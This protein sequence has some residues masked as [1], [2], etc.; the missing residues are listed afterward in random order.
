[1]DVIM[2]TRDLLVL[3]AL[4]RLASSTKLDSLSVYMLGRRTCPAVAGEPLRPTADMSWILDHM[5]D[6]GHKLSLRRLR[7]DNFCV[8]GN[9]TPFQLHQLTD[10]ARLDHLAVSCFSIVSGCNNALQPHTFH[11]SCSQIKQLDETAKFC[12]RE[13]TAESVRHFLSECIRLKELVITDNQEILTEEVVRHLGPQLQDLQYHS[14]SLLSSRSDLKILDP[15]VTL[16][17]SWLAHCRNLLKLTIDTPIPRAKAFVPYVSSY[18][19]SLPSLDRLTCYCVGEP[20]VYATHDE[21][22]PDD[23]K[24]IICDAVSG[25]HEQLLRRQHRL[26]A[27]CIAFEPRPHWDRDP[28]VTRIGRRP[29][30]QSRTFN[31]EI[32]ASLVFGC[33]PTVQAQCMELQEVRRAQRHLFWE[34]HPH[35]WAFALARY[36]KLALEESAVVRRT[37]SGLIETQVQSCSR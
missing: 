11:L 34:V 31:S 19:E 24:S 4:G 5:L 15:M 37:H 9:E 30:T 25:L 36:S 3:T 21:I 1:M 26:T 8:C 17:S 29:T 13:W 16:P 35:Y 27:F 32:R 2:P 22:V 7:L 20:W 10:I 28:M 12:A 18:L 33:P 6:S 23:R 14:I